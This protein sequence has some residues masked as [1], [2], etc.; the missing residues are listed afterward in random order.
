MGDKAWCSVTAAKAGLELGEHLGPRGWL[1]SSRGT[2]LEGR[3]MANGEADT[4]TPEIHS[5][6]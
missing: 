4:R 1:C 6:Q 5:G 2:G 3:G